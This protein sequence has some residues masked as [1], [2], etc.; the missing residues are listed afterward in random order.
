MVKNRIKEILEKKKI[1]QTT[2]A[3]LLGKSFN[4][5]NIYATNKVQP[6]LVT[7]Y[8]IAELLNVNVRILLVPNDVKHTSDE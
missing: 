4:M 8:N 1:S 6:P 7:L 5:V 3:D 2:L